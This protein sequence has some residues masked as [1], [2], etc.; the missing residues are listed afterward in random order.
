MEWIDVYTYIKKHVYIRYIFMASLLT[1][2]VRI[3]VLFVC[4]QTSQMIPADADMANRKW[5]YRNTQKICGFPYKPF[6][7]SPSFF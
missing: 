6:W 5:L 2:Y 4:L 3:Y 1:P 7:K